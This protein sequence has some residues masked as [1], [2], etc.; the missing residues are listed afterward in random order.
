MLKKILFFAFVFN[1]L[2]A[3]AELKFTG[4]SDVCNLLANSALKGRKWVDYGDGTS[5]C[6]SNYKDIGSGRPLANN[7][8]F[9]ATGVG[10]AVKQVKLVMNVNNPASASSAIKQ[11]SQASAILSTKLL[12]APLPDDVRAAISKGA[13]KTA[14]LGSGSVE[15]LKDV[16]PTGRGYEI[17]VIIK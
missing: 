1:S 7:L 4:P 6:A 3:S 14:V 9:Y 15:V 16:W 2:Q 12:G 8:A 5:G 17:Q 10:Q 13:T 11:L